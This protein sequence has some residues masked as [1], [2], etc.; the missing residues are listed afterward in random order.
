MSAP[1]VHGIGNATTDPE[2]RHTNSGAS[3]ASVTL[4]FNRPFKKKGGDGYEKETTFLKIS[5]WNASGEAFAEKVKKGQPV[6]IDGFLR[7]ENWN[8]K[9]GEKRTSFAVWVN[10]WSLAGS[11]GNGNKAKAAPEKREEKTAAAPEQ[12]ETEPEQLDVPF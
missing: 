11:F 5:V 9:E 1:R 8:N 10:E 3:V 6:Y 4:A 7:Q 12:N 2:L